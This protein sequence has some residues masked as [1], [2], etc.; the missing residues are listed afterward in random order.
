VFKSRLPV[1]PAAGEARNEAAV[2]HPSVANARPRGVAEEAGNQGPKAHVV[3]GAAAGAADGA[4]AD[5]RARS[6]V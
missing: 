4:D 6:P 3:R 5:K 1:R 2:R